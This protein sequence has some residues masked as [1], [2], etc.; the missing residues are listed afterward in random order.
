MS[1][2][3]HVKQNKMNQSGMQSPRSL[4]PPLSLFSLSPCLPLSFFVCLFPHRKRNH[5]CTATRGAQGHDPQPKTLIQRGTKERR[6][7]IQQIRPDHVPRDALLQWGIED[8]RRHGS[9]PVGGI[10]PVWSMNLL[11]QFPFPHLDQ[12]HLKQKKYL[13]KNIWIKFVSHTILYCSSLYLNLSQLYH[14][15]RISEAFFVSSDLLYQF[16]SHC[17]TTHF[18]NC[19][20]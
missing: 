10:D 16:K 5:Q 14:W 13:F 17:E 8:E 2:L 3:L 9:K 18:I 4:Y 19:L 20:Q 6:Q 7:W 11:P 12:V 1:L 15:I